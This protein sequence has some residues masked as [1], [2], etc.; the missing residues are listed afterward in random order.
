MVETQSSKTVVI[1]LKK[2][3]AAK[4]LSISAVCLKVVKVTTFV[5][6]KAVKVTTSDFG[7]SEVL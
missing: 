5:R 6:L 2:K 4:T 7:L 3:F 1:D